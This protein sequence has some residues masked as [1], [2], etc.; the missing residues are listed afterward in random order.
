MPGAVIEASNDDTTYDILHTVGSDAHTGW[1]AIHPTIATNYRY[2][3]L[4][5]D[6]TSGCKIAEFEVSGVLYND[7]SV[8]TDDT[9]VDVTIIDGAS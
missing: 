2:F 4:R 3:R 8:S 7:I 5:H 9:T 6:S 1:N